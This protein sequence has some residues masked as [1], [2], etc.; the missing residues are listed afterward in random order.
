M[1]VFKVRNS[2]GL[3]WEGHANNKFTKKGKAWKEIK[4]IKLAFRNGNRQID[5]TNKY[6][7]Y[8]PNYLT[9]CEIVKFELKEVATIKI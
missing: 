4:H 9:D 1:E 5:Y 8:T 6:I 2:E 3:F 7:Q